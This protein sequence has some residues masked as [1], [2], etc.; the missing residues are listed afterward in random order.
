MDRPVSAGR[1]QPI[2]AEAHREYVP[3]QSQFD[4]FAS[5]LLRFSFEQR[6]HQYCRSIAALWRTPGGIATDAFGEFAL[7]ISGSLF[8]CHSVPLGG[9][10]ASTRHFRSLRPAGGQNPPHPRVP[11]WGGTKSLS[12]P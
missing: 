12:S 4:E 11:T 8:R 9:F 6:L 2:D 3:S 10:T 5:Q 7:T 1:E